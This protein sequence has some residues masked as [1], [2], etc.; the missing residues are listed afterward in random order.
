MWQAYIAFALKSLMDADTHY[1]NIKWE[2]LAIIY[3]CEYFN[4]Y[5]HSCSFTVEMDD[6]PLEMIALNLTVT[7]LTCKE[8][9][10]FYNNMMPLIGTDLEM[11][12][13][14]QITCPGSPTSGRYMKLPYLCVWIMLLSVPS[15][16]LKY[17]R[18][19]RAS[20]CCLLSIGSC[21]MDSL[22]YEDK[23]QE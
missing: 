17:A 16:W 14:S 3:V 9:S 21:T 7:S 22:P 23:V 15:G 20:W 12:C 18:R 4:N 6:K 5:L 10:Y 13:I 8:C 19:P 2:L 11:K 1:A